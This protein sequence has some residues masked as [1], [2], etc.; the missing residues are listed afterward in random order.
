MNFKNKLIEDNE[1]YI[2]SQQGKYKPF[3]F[4]EAIAKVDE[5]FYSEA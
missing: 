2:H 5:L 4:Q 3:K 1:K